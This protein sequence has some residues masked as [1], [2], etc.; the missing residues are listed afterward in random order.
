MTCRLVLFP[1]Q[2]FFFKRNDA[3]KKIEDNEEFGAA[4]DIDMKVRGIGRII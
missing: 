1:C 3:F 2:Q 4:W